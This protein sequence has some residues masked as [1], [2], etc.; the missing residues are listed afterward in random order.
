MTQKILVVEDDASQR[1][2]IVEMLEK[3]GFLTAEA[4]SGRAALAILQQ[5]KNI[6]LVLADYM[7]PGMDGIELL[8]N[9]QRQYQRLPAIILTGTQDISV[10]VKAM[11][12]GAKDFLIKPPEIERLQVSIQ[13]ALKLSGL[14]E[15]VARLRRQRDGVLAFKDLIGG[16]GGLESVVQTGRRAAAANIPVLLTGETGVGKEVFARAIH[17]ESARCGKPFVAVNCGAIPEKLVES[18]LFG[19]EKGAFTGA[20]SKAFGRFREAE[21]GT[22]FLDEVGELP[23]DA[24]VKLLRVLQQKEVTPVGASRSISIN[25][26]VI[27][28]T[29]RDLAA[30]VKAGKFREDLYFRLKVLGIHLPALRE[31]REDIPVLIRYFIERIGAGEALGARSISARALEELSSRNWPGNVR[32]LENAIHRALVLSE[33]D[34]LEVEDFEPALAPQASFPV[35]ATTNGLPLFMPDGQP[36]TLHMLQQEI[37]RFA[38]QHCGQNISKAAAMLDVARSTFYRK[39][40]GDTP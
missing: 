30:D 10:V 39:A 19:H 6:G 3:S 17:G 8:E 18:T 11:R 12:L 5:D 29:N 36:K 24:Q 25:V 28:A 27:S 4:A 37:M 35:P 20:V 23:Q 16:E 7:M 40:G 22:I 9:I 38:L 34:V 15:E 1:M 14:E 13:N 32:E 33:R 21:G 26:R 2:M 31:R